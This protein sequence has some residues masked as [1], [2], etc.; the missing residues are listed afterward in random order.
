MG[1][2]DQTEAL[3]PL[4][5]F[6]AAAFHAGKAPQEVC[7]FVLSLA[8]VYNDLRD[9]VLG[10]VLIQDVAPADTHIKTTRLGQAAGLGIHLLRV[11]AGIVHELLQLVKDQSRAIGQP[12]F[13]EL[14]RLLTPAGRAAWLTLE[15]AANDRWQDNPLS[16]AVFFARNKVGYHY[17]PK[18]LARGYGL[19]FGNSDP[20]LLSRGD[21]MKST[22]FYFADA[23]AAAYMHDKADSE[24][25]RSFLKGSGMFL[26]Q[27]NRALYELVTRFVPWQGHGW[28]TGPRA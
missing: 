26:E 11:Q 20:P 5:A 28:R 21:K 15:A 10:H 2:A 27:I 18:E 25:A 8:L 7:N 13:Q 3:E 23:A 24:E 17:D 19:R 22:R 14:L 12:A 6:D 1:Y 16:R 4:E 9:V